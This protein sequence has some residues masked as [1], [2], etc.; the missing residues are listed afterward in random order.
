M[1][2]VAN[3]PLYRTRR[4]VA[5]LRQ[6]VNLMGTNAAITVALSFSLVRSLNREE[7]IRFWKRS[8]LSA[9]ACRTLAEHFRFNPDDLMLA[10]SL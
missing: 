2:K 4:T 6:A 8:L 7:E 5:N 3:S 9:L 1:R 10:G